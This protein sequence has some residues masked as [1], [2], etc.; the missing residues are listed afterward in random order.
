LVQP[1]RRNFARSE[2]TT[3]GRKFVHGRALEMDLI[4]HATRDLMTFRASR[5]TQLSSSRFG[6][7][8]ERVFSKLVVDEEAAG[9]EAH[10]NA[11]AWTAKADAILKAA[12]A[13]GHN[14]FY[15]SNH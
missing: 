4:V 7:L 9:S 10:S 5:P 2:G 11:A 14:S 15:I 6:I 3:V 1:R 13:K 8:A 12:A